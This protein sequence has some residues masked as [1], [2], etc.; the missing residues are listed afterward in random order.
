MKTQPQK[1]TKS[2]AKKIDRY[3]AID[4]EKLDTLPSS[5][6]S[7]GLAVIENNKVTKKYYSLICPPSKNENYYCVQTH[8]LH[9]RDVKDAP[10]FPEIWKEFDKIIDGAPLISHNYGVE[11]GCIAACNEEFG[12]NYNYNYIC[13]LA[14]SRKYLKHLPSKKLDLVCEA[15]NYKMKNHHNA[16]ADAVACA[17]LFIRL[18]KKYNLKDEERKKLFAKPKRT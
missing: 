7:V 17:E 14:L 5:I 3:V 8:G 16:L 1:K 12:T 10:T 13:T 4:F 6:C 9:Y 15:M 18:K 2:Q 11:R